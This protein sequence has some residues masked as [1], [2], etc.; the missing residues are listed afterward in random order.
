[1]IKEQNQKLFFDRISNIDNPLAKLTKEPT[2]S[3]Q[4]NKI[5]NEKENITTET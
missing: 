1:M 5:R 4:I 2:G 3:I